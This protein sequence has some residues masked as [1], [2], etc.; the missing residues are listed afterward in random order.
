MSSAHLDIL[1]QSIAEANRML[2]QCR[3]ELMGNDDMFIYHRN[4]LQHL[5]GR[6]TQEQYY[7][8][9]KDDFAL[10]RVRTLAVIK[11]YDVLYDQIC[12]KNLDL[13]DMKNKFIAGED[14]RW[15][16]VFSGIEKGNLIGGEDVGYYAIITLRRFGSEEVFDIGKKI[17]AEYHSHHDRI[18]GVLKEMRLYHDYIHL[19]EQI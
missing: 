13:E 8:S 18:S 6:N 14:P 3:Q 16:S 12:R 10:L 7:W 5:S 2:N 1:V 17:S 9:D 15:I 4:F 11:Q 19:C